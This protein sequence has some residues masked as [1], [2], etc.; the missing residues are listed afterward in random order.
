MKET[1]FTESQGV[2]AIQKQETGISVKDICRENKN[3]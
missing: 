3:K 2:A 1:R